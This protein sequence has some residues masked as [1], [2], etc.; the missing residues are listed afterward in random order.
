MCPVRN[1]TY[2]SGRSHVK[3]RDVCGPSGIPS[4]N[5]RFRVALYVSTPLSEPRYARRQRATTN[6][7]CGSMRHDDDTCD[8]RLS[9][10]AR[11]QGEAVR[12]HDRDRRQ[13]QR[14]IEPLSRAEIAGGHRARPH[15]PITGCRRRPAIDIV[16]G[17]GIIFPRDESGHAARARH[18]A[19]ESRQPEA[20]ILGRGLRLRHRP[21]TAAAGCNI[22]V[23][24]RPGDQIRK[25]V[26]R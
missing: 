4:L 16:G 14:Q 21:R 11:H 15:H 1:V 18:G 17:P 3:P 26:D 13:W 9:F 20:W 22:E 12:T 2:V 6:D 25:P 10:P 5:D 24:E 8:L 7:R 19:E 23:R